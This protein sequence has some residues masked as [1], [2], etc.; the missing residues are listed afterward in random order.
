MRANA[1][2]TAAEGPGSRPRAIRAA[3]YT[4]ITYCEPRGG[5]S[6]VLIRR[7]EVQKN[8]HGAC[9]GGQALQKRADGRQARS[10]SRAR[11]SLGGPPPAAPGAQRSTGY[12][13]PT[14]DNEHYGALYAALPMLDVAGTGAE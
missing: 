14:I 4:Q 7:A 5:A 2:A 11:A 13:P 3:P 10:V 6:K 1:Q 8:A 9:S 12:R